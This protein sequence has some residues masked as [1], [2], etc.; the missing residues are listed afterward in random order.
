[1]DP[2]TAINLAVTGL[3]LVEQLLPVI[4]QMRLSGDITA[5][6]QAEVRARYESLKARA[7]GQ[8]NGPEW[9]RA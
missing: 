2:V 7:D 1:M 9:Q 5:A 3:N 6:Q 4:E 8:F